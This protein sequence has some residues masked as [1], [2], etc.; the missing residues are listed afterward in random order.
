MIGIIKESKA[1]QLAKTLIQ[2]YIE[3]LSKTIYGDKVN[4][5]Q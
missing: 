2:S 4:Q 3:N 5:E 1:I